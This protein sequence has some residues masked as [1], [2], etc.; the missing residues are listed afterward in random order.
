[1]NKKK[2]QQDLINYENRFNELFQY[3]NHKD[4]IDNTRGCEYL[5]EIGYLNKQ[6]EFLTNLLPYI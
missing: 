6:I 4:N 2:I 1:M 3:V 5:P